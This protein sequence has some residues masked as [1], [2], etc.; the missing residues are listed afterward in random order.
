MKSGEFWRLGHVSD[1]HL[2]TGIFDLL[3]GGA[4]IEA[5]LIAHLAEVEGRRLYLVDGYSA[6]FHY[7][8]KHL[9]MSEGE[10]FLRIAAA[11]TARKFPIVFEMVARHEIHLTGVCLLRDHLT[12][13]NHADLLGEAAG[14]SKMHVLELLARRFPGES[15]D[16]RVRKLP[17]Q[18]RELPQV[19]AASAVAGEQTSVSSALDE[20]TCLLPRRGPPPAQIGSKARSKRCY[21]S[22]TSATACSST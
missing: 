4:R 8:Q 16:A 3:A 19:A 9:R 17:E 6:M 13:D 12:T 14:K 2:R 1:E 10:A 7:C 22:L 21:P 5:L 15:A 11:R 20:T 18:K